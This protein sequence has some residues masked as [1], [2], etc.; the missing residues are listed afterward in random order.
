MESLAEVAYDTWAV[1]VLL[2]AVVVL[3]IIDK[4]VSRIGLE[5]AWTDLAKERDLKIYRGGLF[6]RR[7]ALRGEV[8]GHE[9][10]ISRTSRLGIP[11][12]QPMTAYEVELAEPVPKENSEVRDELVKLEDRSQSVSMEDQLLR[13]EV[14]GIAGDRGAM[15]V[16]LD[17]V[18]EV[19]ERIG[20]G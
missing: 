10:A 4:I 15:S 1:V 11:L 14:P 5:G 3:I 19:V 13:V 12:K 9:V 2:G 8:D 7:R 6:L 20:D 18:M 16:M 17:H